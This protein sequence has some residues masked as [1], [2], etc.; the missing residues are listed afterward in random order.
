[1][2]TPTP[3]DAKNIKCK[4]KG[5]AYNSEADRRSWEAMKAFFGEILK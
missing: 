1:L 4:S 3:A 5:V 2:D